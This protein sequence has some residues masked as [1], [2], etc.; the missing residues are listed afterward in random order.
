LGDADA[1]PEVPLSDEEKTKLLG[2]CS[3]GIEVTQ[4]IDATMEHNQMLKMAQFTW[5]RKDTMGRPLYHLG[6]REFYP[7]GAP[8]VR[9]RFAEDGNAVAMMVSDGD[10]TMTA[11]RG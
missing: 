10:M 2:T 11:R 4:Q 8:D 3:F 1:D 5:T 7:A 9:I 6:R